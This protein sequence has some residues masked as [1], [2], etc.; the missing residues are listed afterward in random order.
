M[1]LLRYAIRFYT[2]LLLIREAWEVAYKVYLKGGGEVY[3]AGGA[4]EVGAER[5]LIKSEMGK[6]PYKVNPKSNIY[7][8]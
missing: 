8:D 7:L 5:L 3:V 6:D 1:I 4:G 2:Y